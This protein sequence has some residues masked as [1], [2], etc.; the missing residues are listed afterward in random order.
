ML[1][2]TLTGGQILYGINDPG[3]S[4]SFMG[5]LYPN[6]VSGHNVSFRVNCF[7]E[8]NLV[9]RLFNALGQTVIQSEVQLVTGPNTVE[10]NIS[11]LR[12]GPYYLKIQTSDDKVII[13]KL[14]VIGETH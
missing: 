13:R 1:P 7:R 3:A 12:A 14:T 11:G 10:L 9:L 2:F 5:E 8:I 4:I 6:P